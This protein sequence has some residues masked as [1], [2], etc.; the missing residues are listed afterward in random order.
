MSAFSVSAD[1]AWSD[2]RWL[3]LFSPGIPLSFSLSILAFSLTGQ[4]LY[5]LFAPLVIHL[6]IPVLDV[7]FGE[8]FSNPP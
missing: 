8:D 7:V 2:K 5:L 3:W 1:P 4:W 6:V